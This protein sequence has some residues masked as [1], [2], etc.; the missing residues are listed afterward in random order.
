MHHKQVGTP[1]EV[2]NAATT[3]RFCP[4]CPSHKLAFAARVCQRSFIWT[5]PC[6]MRDNHLSRYRRDPRRLIFF[7]QRSKDLA[8]RIRPLRLEPRCTPEQ[9]STKK[10]VIGQTSQRALEVTRELWDADQNWCKSGEWWPQQGRVGRRCP[11][12]LHQNPL[13]LAFQRE[14][15]VACLLLFE[16]T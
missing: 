2:D 16:G 10:K 3:D 6:L 13:A 7:D 9:L 1:P 4:S 14:R 5:V 11:F 15:Y 8:Q 12:S